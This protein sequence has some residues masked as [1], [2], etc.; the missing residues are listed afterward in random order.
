MK[1]T[2][3]K[4]W[5]KCNKIYF[6]G[7]HAA[8]KSISIYDHPFGRNNQIMEGGHHGT[9]NKGEFDSGFTARGSFLRWI[10]TAQKEE[11]AFPN[12]DS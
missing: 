7:S 5:N 10:S 12:R 8:F 9:I 2:A 3:L 6:N 11:V 4:I 1:R